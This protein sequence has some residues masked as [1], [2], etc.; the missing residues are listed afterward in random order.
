M[1]LFPHGKED[2]IAAKHAENLQRKFESL[3]QAGDFIKARECSEQLKQDSMTDSYL[4]GVVLSFINTSRIESYFQQF[5]GA[6]DNLMK[7]LEI[8]EKLKNRQFSSTVYENLG[9]CYSQSGNYEKGL[10]L[11]LKSLEYYPSN[12][13][14]LTNAGN[15]YLHLNE[16]D[17]A[18]KCTQ[19]AIEIHTQKGNLSS[20]A[21]AVNNLGEILFKEG[22]HK[23]AILQYDIVLSIGLKE[24][25]SHIIGMA[26]LGKAQIYKIEKKFDIALESISNALESAKQKNDNYLIEQCYIFYSEIYKLTGEYKKA[27]FYTEQKQLEKEKLLNIETRQKLNKMQDK[28]NFKIADQKQRESLLIASQKKIQKRFKHLQSAYAEV[29]GIG[30]IGMFSSIMQDIVTIAN[31]FHEDRKVPVLIEGETGTGKEI[32]ARIIHH[33][34]S[35]SV[36]PFVVINCAAI[37]PS[38]FESE[39]FGYEEGAFT[40]AKKSGSIGKFEIAQGG[41]LF[42]DE[43]GD[44]P[45][46]LQPK[47]LRTL[48]QKELYRI[49]GKKPI[50][51]D[52]RVICATNR[53]LQN[54]I[55]QNRFR[56]DLFYRLNTGRIFIPPLTERKEEITKLAHMFL[57]KFS[58]E[59]NKQFHSISPP[60]E[61]ML[62]DYNW[63]GNVRELENCIERIVLLNDE[64]ILLPHHLHFLEYDGNHDQKIDY[65]YLHLNFPDEGVTFGEINRAVIKKVLELFSGNKTQAAKYLKVSRNTIH[66]ILNR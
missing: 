47:L 7:A 48:Q 26:Y 28:Y 39:L 64:E 36:V 50:K 43:I 25:N 35:K 37:S 9:I 1:N 40:D 24:N 44:L 52:V 62:K 5:G 41:T 16:L 6:I 11:I 49:G 63:K 33:G 59:K 8:C 23:Q 45:I 12:S 66:N 13:H 3:F 2:E 34:K 51:L 55:D 4:P 38:L 18:M 57:T 32:I 53:N 60:A 22:K 14:A 17:K 15:I 58:K 27:L 30:E 29:T 20:K 19:K 46:D 61:K 21:Y 31:R 10:E 42:L 56:R 54:E 65:K